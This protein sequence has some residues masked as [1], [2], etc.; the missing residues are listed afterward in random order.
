MIPHQTPLVTLI[1]VNYNGTPDTLELI[2]SLQMQSYPNW[3]LI[4]VDN[5]SDIPPK[6][7]IQKQYPQVKVI[8]L[9]RNIGFAGG[10]NIGIKA[11]KGLYYFFVN[12][13]TVLEPTC[14]S[15]L[16]ETALHT[17]KLGALSPKFHFYHHPKLIEFGGFSKINTISAR[18]HALHYKEKDQGLRGLI[19]TYYAHGAGM[20]VPKSVVEKVGM[21]KE[22]FFLYYEEM[23]WCERI[24]RAGFNI[25]CQ[26]DALMHHK[27]SATVG[28]LNPLK[29]YY[30]NRNRIWFMRRNY[31]FPRNLPFL[32]FLIFLSIP[33]N[34]LR[35][36]LKAE[37]EHLRAY[38]RGVLWHIN[39]RY[40]F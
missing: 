12:N 29:T 40:T 27:E 8:E 35:F 22:D 5:A 25:Y 7:I 36:A 33:I 9:L 18:N 6:D 15:I 34:L 31:P 10:N 20:L 37:W 11:A 39:K 38:S 23:D 30:L 19:K 1:T 21:M 4:V 17:K 16:M 32:F 13:D 3:E 24:R 14:L 2:A 28:K 26:R